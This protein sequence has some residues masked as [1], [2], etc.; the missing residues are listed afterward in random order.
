[1]ADAGKRNSVAG[2][3]ATTKPS[4]AGSRAAVAPMLNTAEALGKAIGAR[5]VLV[6]IRGSSVK[7]G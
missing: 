5:L 3:I 4:A 2:K 1:M 6:M 7:R